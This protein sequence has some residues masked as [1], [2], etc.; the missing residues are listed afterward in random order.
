MTLRL[1]NLASS[2]WSFSLFLLS[3]SLRVGIGDNC[4]PVV[5][6][7]G[8]VG[9]PVSGVDA[10]VGVSAVGGGVCGGVVGVCVGV[11]VGAGVSVGGGDGVCV[12]VGVVVGVGGVSVVALVV[13]VVLLLLLLLLPVML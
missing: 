12:V 13:V 4:G 9:V 8:S 5:F 3:V 2:L 6:G 11:D 10:D 7:G 1:R